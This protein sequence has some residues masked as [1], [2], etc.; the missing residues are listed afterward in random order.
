MAKPEEGT[1]WQVLFSLS[2][3][4]RN[5]GKLARQLTA[6]G[7]GLLVAAGLF[8]LHHGPLLAS[9]SRD[10]RTV[11]VIPLAV[12]AGWLI[13]RIIHYPRFAEFLISV[14]AE[15]AKVSWASRTEVLRATAVVISTMI[16]M[17][18]VLFAYDNMWL[19]V[20]RFI[21]VLHS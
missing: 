4:K 14:E 3:Y 13:F 19:W 18:V 5:Q 10:I 11:V 1:F 15:M 16:F 7:L 6:V 17:T 12:L 21:G 20:L 8:V 2:V 9:L